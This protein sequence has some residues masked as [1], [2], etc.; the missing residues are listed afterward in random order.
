MSEETKKCTKCGEV[1]VLDAF[2]RHKERIRGECKECE[3]VLNRESHAKS[4][5]KWALN[6]AERVKAI[7]AAYRAGLP[8]GAT[9]QRMKKY[10]ED[11]PEKAKQDRA[12]YYAENSNK[13]KEQMKFRRESLLDVYVANSLRVRVADCPPGLITLQREHIQIK[14]LAKEFKRTVKEVFK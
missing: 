11:N 13:I 14:R 2:R 10:R 7:S 8:D 4:A 12:K 1:K 3:K 5:K 9:A 6:N